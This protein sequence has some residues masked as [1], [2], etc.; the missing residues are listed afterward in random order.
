[1]DILRSIA[2]AAYRMGW[3]L[4]ITMKGCRIRF[5]YWWMTIGLY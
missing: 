1:M 3:L 5:I 4:L 2:T